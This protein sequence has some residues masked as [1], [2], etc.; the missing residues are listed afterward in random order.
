MARNWPIA[1]ICALVLTLPAAMLHAQ[2]DSSQLWG[3][4][5]HDTA[6]F[7][8]T[9]SA[10]A[11]NQLSWA[12][13]PVSPGS[14]GSLKVDYTGSK[15]FNAGVTTAALPPQPM[16]V[17]SISAEVYVPAEVAIARLEMGMQVDGSPAATDVVTQPLNVRGGWNLL[18]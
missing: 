14:S 9:P 1:F 6:G 5:T 3:F 10:G 12:S 11:S 15:G 8:S 17:A 4:G 18:S 2:G 16:N 13:S 7:Q